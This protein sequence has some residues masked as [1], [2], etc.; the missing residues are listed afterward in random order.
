VSP[1]IKH[2]KNL[3]IDFKFRLIIKN[4]YPNIKQNINLPKVNDVKLATEMIC[5]Y[6][7]T[8]DVKKGSITEL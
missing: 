1:A 5:K 4:M 3:F 7:I 6:L 2:S 8:G